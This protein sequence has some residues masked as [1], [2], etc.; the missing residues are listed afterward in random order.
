MFT[1]KLFY[2]DW[3]RALTLADTAGVTNRI[4]SL[5]GNGR[6]RNRVAGSADDIRP[7]F[8]GEKVPDVSFK[9][10][11]GKTIKL[12]SLLENGPTV[13][14]FYRGGWCPYC[15]MQLSQLREIEDRILNLGY[16]ITAVSADSPSNV[17]K[18][19]EKH[20]MHYTLL[21]DNTMDAA[22]S[23][24]IAFKVD[25]EGLERGKAHGVSLDEASGFDHHILPV[26][27]VFVVD[28]SGTIL[29]EYVNPDYHVRLSAKVLLAVLKA[30]AEDAAGRSAAG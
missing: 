10:T 30:E 9:D 20:S 24:G 21:S 22:K 1:S 7:L 17:T 12:N 6:S 5:T 15:N 2:G 27:A 3:S 8:V 25:K 19:I 14:V 23:F 4:I 11:E 29:F 28:K 18:S 26:P 13:L 16:Q